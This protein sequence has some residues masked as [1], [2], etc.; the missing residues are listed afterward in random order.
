MSC[1]E[2]IAL[3]LISPS[4][5]VTIIRNSP[6]PLRQSK[7]TMPDTTALTRN[8][9]TGDEEEEEEEEEE[10]EEEAEANVSAAVMQSC[11]IWRGGGPRRCCPLLRPSQRPSLLLP[12]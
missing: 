10:D 1:S 3:T 8:T 6:S 7:L 12:L 9:G 2:I 5:T 11:N 4:S